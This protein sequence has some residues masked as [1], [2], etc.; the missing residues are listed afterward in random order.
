MHDRVFK[1]AMERAQ[2]AAVRVPAQRAAPNVLD[3]VHRIDDVEH[4][5]LIWRAGERKA[6]AR[7]PFGGQDAGYDKALEQLA[8]VVRGNGRR[9]R[10]GRRSQRAI[11]VSRKVDNLT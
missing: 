8:Q 1:M 10:Y 6:A 3:G 5:D 7:T 2:D 11:S 9:G 4:R